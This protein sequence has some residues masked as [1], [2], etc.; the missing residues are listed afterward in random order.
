M[1]PRNESKIEA[2]F[3]FEKDEW[4]ESSLIAMQALHLLGKEEELRLT[5][6]KNSDS[7]TRIVQIPPWKSGHTHLRAASNSK[8]GT[9]RCL[10]GLLERRT[11]EGKGIGFLPL[12]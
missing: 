7:A 1:D 3:F 4:R 5:Q 11:Q 6:M 9:L 12:F 2:F 10:Q 8:L